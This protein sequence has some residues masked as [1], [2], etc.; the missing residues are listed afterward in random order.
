MSDSMTRGQIKEATNIADSVAV[1]Y[2]C[3]Q[4]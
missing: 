3:L 2:L 4:K 1:T